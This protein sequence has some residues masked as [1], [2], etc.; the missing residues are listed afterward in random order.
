MNND[1]PLLLFCGVLAYPLFLLF[2]GV[3]ILWEHLRNEQPFN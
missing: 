2:R 1:W 3:R